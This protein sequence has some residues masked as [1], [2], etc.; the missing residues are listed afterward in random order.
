[1]NTIPT[2]LVINAAIAKKFGAKVKLIRSAFL[3]GSVVPDVPLGLISL[4]YLVYFRFFTTQDISG[5]MDKA[6]GE[7]YF[8][9]PMWIAGHNLLHSPTAL[10]VY[11][12]FLWRFLK[13]PGSAGSWWLSFVMG[14]MV[15]T[16][17]DILTHH[18]DGPLLFWPFNWQTRFYSPVSYWDRAHFGSQFVYVEIGINLLL[19]CYLLL[20]VVIQKLRKAN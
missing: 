15:H 7:M 17:I 20:P 3:W 6:F 9:N 18:D 16:G 11:I 4:A 2:H 10:G 1:M 12:V 19:L 5:F 8:S 13:K 14:C